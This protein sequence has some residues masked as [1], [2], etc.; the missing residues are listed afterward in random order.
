[1]TSPDHQPQ[2]PPLLASEGWHRFVTGFALLGCTGLILSG[3]FYPA[4]L[5][6]MGGCYL[7]RELRRPIARSRRENRNT[8]P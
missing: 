7:L 2:K 5:G 3:E 8:L 4:L 6:A 1:M